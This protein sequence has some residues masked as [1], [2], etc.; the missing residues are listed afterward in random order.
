MIKTL[1]VLFTFCWSNIHIAAHAQLRGYRFLN[2]KQYEEL[3]IKLVNQLPVISVIINN[4]KELNFVLDTGMR[5]TIILGKKH[6]KGLKYELGREIKFAGLGDEQLVSGNMITNNK[7]NIGNHVEGTGISMVVINDKHKLQKEFSRL[8]I[9]GIIGYELFARFIVEI[10]YHNKL[11]NILE[12]GYFDFDDV[13]G[14]VPI[15]I[16]NTKPYLMANL[17]TKEM[18][19]WRNARLMLDTGSSTT[20]M[21]K[22]CQAMSFVNDQIVAKGLSGIVKGIIGYLENIEFGEFNLAGIPIYIVDHNRFMDADNNDTRIGSIGGGLFAA[23][24]IA[25]DYANRYLY[26]KRTHP[27]HDKVIVNL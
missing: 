5:S 3:P 9:H 10:D 11:L 23:Y 4:T 14:K 8:N 16:D 1:L 20:I 13:Y 27:S 25:F 17:K 12:Q 21:L 24:S 22:K 19:E 6:L 15:A 7:I 2:G 18:G 26:L